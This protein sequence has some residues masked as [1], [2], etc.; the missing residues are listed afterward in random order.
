[1][2]DPRAFLFIHHDPDAESVSIPVRLD[3]RRNR[4]VDAGVLA[5]IVGLLILVVRWIS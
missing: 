5:G 1:M 3:L 2:S 4:L